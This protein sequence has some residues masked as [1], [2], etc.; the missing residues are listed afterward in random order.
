[1]GQAGVGSPQRVCYYGSMHFLAAHKWLSFAVIALV[2]LILFVLWQALFV[3]YHYA[4]V[5]PVPNIPRGTETF[6]AEGAPLRFVVL[7]DSTAV[8]QGAD[9]A[10]GIARRSAAHLAQSRRVECTNVGVSGARVADVLQRQVPQ[11]AA[12]HPDVVL[13]A[14]GAN[15]VTHLTSLGSVR[16]NI[17]AVIAQLRTANP[18]VKIILTGSPAMGSVPRFAP[19]TQWLLAWRTRHIND[20]FAAAAKQQ[21]AILLPIAAQTAATFKHDPH[22]FAADA[23]HPNAAGY[24]IW[25]PIINASLAKA[26][27]LMK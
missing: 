19:P 22:L 6:G 24:A 11:V 3:L 15:D 16:Q 8:G 4:A 25:Q 18:Q 9:Y 2:L 20:V 12:L 23:F 17:A 21:S 27:L 14:V 1:M 10:D 13:V 5:V 7:G 26:G